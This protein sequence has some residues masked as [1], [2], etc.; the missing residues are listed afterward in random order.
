MNQYV[1]VL[2]TRYS[3]ETRKW[4]DD[5]K[6]HDAYGYIEPMSKEIIMREPAT[7]CLTV[8]QS[9]RCFEEDLR[10]EIVHAFLKECGMTAWY[11]DEA[12]V[13]WIAQM[14]PR[15]VAAMQE[16]GAMPHADG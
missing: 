7:N 6:L 1:M 14:I 4:D 3:I 5:R 8:K 16:A 15:M 13:E 12:L 11:D 10:H 2:G 9:E